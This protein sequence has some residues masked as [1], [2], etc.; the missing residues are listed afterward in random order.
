LA[1]PALSING[2][3]REDCAAPEN[4]FVVPAECFVGGPATKHS[5]RTASRMCFSS[6]AAGA[7]WPVW[8]GLPQFDPF[9]SDGTAT[10][11]IL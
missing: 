10:T 3:F 1:P 8:S 11:T 4:G 5:E 2:R 7:G 6:Y 9:F